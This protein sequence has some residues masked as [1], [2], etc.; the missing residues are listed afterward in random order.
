MSGLLLS[1][2]LLSVVLFVRSFFFVRDNFCQFFVSFCQFIG[3]VISLQGSIFV[4]GILCRFFLSGQILLSVILS[5]VFSCKRQLMSG[6][7]L[8]R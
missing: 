4:R 3:L 8:T 1:G 7:F 2:Q 6:L 5:G